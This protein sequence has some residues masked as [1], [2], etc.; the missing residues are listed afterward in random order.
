M[1]TNTTSGLYSPRVSSRYL[2]VAK[3][4]PYQGSMTVL[5]TRLAALEFHDVTFI[6]K[7]ADVFYHLSEVSSNGSTV[8]TDAE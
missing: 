5:S 3:E 2:C 7:V 1:Y 6:A 8:A 4:L